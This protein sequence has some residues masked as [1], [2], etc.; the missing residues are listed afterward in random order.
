MLGSFQETISPLQ[1]VLQ[2]LL[3]HLLTSKCHQLSRVWF[4]KDVF[5]RTGNSAA[6]PT[7][8]CNVRGIR[9]A[10]LSLEAYVGEWRPQIT[11]FLCLSIQLIPMW[12]PMIQSNIK[13]SHPR[14]D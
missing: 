1:C 4:Q 5:L 11:R 3:G 14:V 13:V 8:F 10:Q 6:G 7:A 12:L 9:W 2:A